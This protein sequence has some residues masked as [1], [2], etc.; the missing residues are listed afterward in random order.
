MQAIAI[1]LVTMCLRSMI[2]INMN[3]AHQ[4][5]SFV[6]LNSHQPFDLTQNPSAHTIR[7]VWA[8]YYIFV[9]P[10]GERTKNPL[11]LSNSSEITIIPSI[12]FSS[13]RQ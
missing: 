13:T 12:H 1:T 2:N 11:A 8:E 4:T 9:P 3:N 7:P 10:L 5:I 6:P